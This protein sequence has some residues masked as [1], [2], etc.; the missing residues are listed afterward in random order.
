VLLV[1]LLTTACAS[2]R[3]QTVEHPGRP[4]PDLALVERQMLA[5]AL[6]TIAAHLPDS[7]ALCLSFMGG[8]DGPVFPDDAFLASLRTRRH[9]LR[10]DNC[11][12][13]YT[14]MI[15]HADDP[16]RGFGRTA[17]RSCAATG[18]RRSLSTHGRSPAISNAR[19]RVD[20]CPPTTRHGGASIPLCSAGLRATGVGW[21]SCD[22]QL[23]TLT[24]GRNSAACSLTSA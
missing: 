22:R 14:Q 20:S 2:R 16:P 11:P 24:N 1:A 18:I 3:S 19:L 12:P 23:G 4:L 7:T 6:D 17:S 15:R 8:P 10:G 5:A 13:T 21:L 9:V